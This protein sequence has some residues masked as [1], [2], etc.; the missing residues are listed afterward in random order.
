M[1]L[2][3]DPAAT[4]HHSSSSSSG[5]WSCG[6]DVKAGHQVAMKQAEV[7]HVSMSP[8][9]DV[10]GRGCGGW[11]A[12]P[13]STSTATAPRWSDPRASPRTW[14][15]RVARPSCSPATRR[16]PSSSSRRRYLV[17]QSQQ[18]RSRKRNGKDLKAQIHYPA[19]RKR[20][21]VE[22]VYV[23]FKTI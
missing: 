3:L 22:T 13:S 15:R 18:S 16:K 4:S 21:K 20:I 19:K 2:Q 10:A 11:R 12:S 7:A 14:S 1:T 5:S 23:G 9:L 6:G 17:H 8:V